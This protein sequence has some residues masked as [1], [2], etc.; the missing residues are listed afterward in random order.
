MKQLVTIYKINDWDLSQTK[1][2]SFIEDKVKLVELHYSSI[3]LLLPEAEQYAK[4]LASEYE[5]TLADVDF[6]Y[7]I[8]H[9]V[10]DINI[11]C[12]KE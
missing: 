2:D 8:S 4:E 3:T 11:Y 5:L 9:D 12:Y 7:F 6:R 10:A 1:L